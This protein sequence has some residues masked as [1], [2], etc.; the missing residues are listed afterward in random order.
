MGG[1]FGIASKQQCNY[2][3]YYGVDYHSHLGTRR[4]GMAMYDRELGFQRQIHNIEN[5]PFRTKFEKDVDEMRGCIG[6]A[7]ISDYE[8]QPLL[9]RSHLGSFAI[10]TVGKINNEDALAELVL[11]KNHHFL[12]LGGGNINPTELVAALI[13]EANTI[14]EGIRFAQRMIDGSMSI[15]VL[16]KDCIYAARDFYGRLPVLIGQNENGYAVSIESFAY[17]KA[18]FD[19]CRDLGPGEIV[20]ITPEGVEQMQVPERKKRICAFLWTY[21][22]YPNSH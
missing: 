8:P 2:D 1:F 15:L 10:C 5:S 19:Y 17:E 16:T 4:G 11:N 9:I 20:R 6:I 14:H 13:N 21:Y 3:L 22:G 18:G 7:C 12:E